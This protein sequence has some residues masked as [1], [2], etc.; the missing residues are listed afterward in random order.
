MPE[1]DTRFE[2]G[3][4]TGDLVLPPPPD[5]SR[6]IP[7]DIQIN[8]VFYPIVRRP[9]LFRYAELRQAENPEYSDVGELPDG[10]DPDDIEYQDLVLL[11]KLWCLEFDVDI[12][13]GRKTLRV[14]FLWRDF[15]S[16][17]SDIEQTIAAFPQGARTYL[18]HSLYPVTVHMNQAQP[19]DCRM[20]AGY[21]V[22]KT[23][24]EIRYVEYKPTPFGML[25]EDREEAERTAPATAADVRTMGLE[26]GAVRLENLRIREALGQNILRVVQRA[27][28][29]YI[30]M[31]LCVL[32]AGSV[33][34]AAK[35]LGKAVST[36]SE[37]LKIKA[38]ESAEHR[39]MYRMIDTRRRN[40][41]VKSIE[42]FNEGWDEHQGCQGGA[43]SIADILKTVVEGLEGMRPDNFHSLKDELVELCSPFL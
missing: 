24:H 4:T 37:K 11:S 29:E 20:D 5:C 32:A 25:P 9:R 2:M 13:G 39:A 8:G 10:G 30:K 16:S 3:R 21:E 15:R 35:K 18:G 31:I 40:C 33:S 17:Y 12:Q 34:K 42:R 6:W 28:P 23:V 14:Q 41:G 27:D 1:G 7:R 19:C 38:G 43:E 22:W 26:F 36:F